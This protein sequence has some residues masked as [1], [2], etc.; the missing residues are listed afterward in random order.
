[1]TKLKLQ[2]ELENS[3]I[4]ANTLMNRERVISVGNS[5]QRELSFDIIDFLNNRLRDENQV[6]WLDICCGSGKALIESAKILNGENIKITG[7]DLVGM[8]DEF[9]EK[10][11]NLELVETSFEDFKLTCEFDLITCV[12][13][14]HYIGD[15]L[16]FIKKSVSNLKSNGIFLANLDLA[17]FKFQNKKSS[18]RE[19]VKELKNK[20]L[21]YNSRKHLLICNGKKEFESNFKYLGANDKAGANYTKQ[22]VVDSYYE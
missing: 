8:F 4:V 19:V 15:K 21:E 10:L 12:H 2:K 20:D 18:G 17:N 3:P 6:N 5:Y 22:D 16:D 1:M 9:S 11:N 13:G 7:I 14:L